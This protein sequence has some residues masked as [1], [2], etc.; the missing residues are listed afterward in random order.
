[1]LYALIGLYLVAGFIIARI[2]EEAYP[3]EDEGWRIPLIL[4]VTL[5]WLPGGGFYYLFGSFRGRKNVE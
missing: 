1:M 2:L 4:L 3:R 5:L